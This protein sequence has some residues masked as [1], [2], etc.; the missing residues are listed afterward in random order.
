MRPRP[1]LVSERRRFA[2]NRRALAARGGRVGFLGLA[3][4]SPS[5]SRASRRSSAISRLRACDRVSSTTTRTSAPNLATSRSRTS[6]STSPAVVRSTTA[7]TRVLE[8]LAC[9]PPGPPEGPKRHTTAVAGTPPPGNLS[10]PSMQTTLHA[11]TRPPA[12]TESTGV[13][14]TPE[15]SVL[16]HP[17]RHNQMCRDLPATTH[18]GIETR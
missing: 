9:C 13:R 7:S 18:S 4:A 6:G 16:T 5:R 17:G 12:G 1:R 14:A 3:T 11:V 10:T 8:R 15:A 2:C